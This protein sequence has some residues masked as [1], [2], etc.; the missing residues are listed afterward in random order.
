MSKISRFKESTVI[1]YADCTQLSNLNLSDYDD[2]MISESNFRFSEIR[3]SIFDK[4]IFIKN[5]FKG[6]YF[7]HV[8]F[9]RSLFKE[10]LF[11]RTIF[12]DCDF[13]GASFRMQSFVECKFVNCKFANTFLNY[14][15]FVDCGF[16]KCDFTMA[17]MPNYFRP[18]CM[19]DCIN[20]PYM[21]MACPDEGE[22][23]GYKI[24]VWENGKRSQPETYYV[25]VTLRIPSDAKRSAAGGRKCRCNKAEVIAIEPVEKKYKGMTMYAAC[26][27]HDSSFKYRVGEEVFVQEFDEDPWNECAPGIHFF[28]NKKEALSYFGLNISSF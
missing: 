23:I 22:F 21:P 9:K 12:M 16:R 13:T 28:M 26:S 10:N 6:A 1:F 14:V 8:S 27:I 5:K 25:L 11:E 19:E 20:V 7:V 3:N 4:V 15:P 24:A 17:D 2:L 18:N